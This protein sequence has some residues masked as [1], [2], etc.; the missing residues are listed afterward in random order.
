MA[1]INV[2]TDAATGETTQREFSPDEVNE[3]NIQAAASEKVAALSELSAIDASSIRAIREYIASKA[4][5]PQ[6]LKDKEA[7]A[8]SARSKL[9]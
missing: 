4:D 8:V 2:I 7:A 3:Y 6:I 5:A 1:L 9:K